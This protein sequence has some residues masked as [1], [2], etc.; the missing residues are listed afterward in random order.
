MGA[1]GGGEA[2]QTRPSAARSSVACPAA[3]CTR[4]EPRGGVLWQPCRRATVPRGRPSW[5]VR[6]W[7]ELDPAQRKP[8]DLSCL[9]GHL[10]RESHD[11]P[12]LPRLEG[13]TGLV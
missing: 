4:H 9:R 7:T 5:R 1:S 3:G 12:K 11:R 13:V 2:A 6:D 8:R 10:I